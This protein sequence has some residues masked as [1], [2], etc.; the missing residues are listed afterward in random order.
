M[1]RETLRTIWIGTALASGIAVVITLIAT[2]GMIPKWSICALVVLG[3]VFFY[4]AAVGIGWLPY[5]VLRNT[6]EML[7]LGFIL[8]GMVSLGIAVRPSPP[9]PIFRPAIVV[10]PKWVRFNAGLVGETYS[11]SV[12]NMTESDMYSVVLKI[13]IESASAQDKFSITP[14]KESMR[15]IYKNGCGSLDEPVMLGMTDNNTHFHSSWVLFF[16]LEGH[17]RRDITVEPMNELSHAVNVSALVLGD[18]IKEQPLIQ[19]QDGFKYRFLD[20]WISVTCQPKT[21]H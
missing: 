11:F 9:K 2:A 16:K 8:V 13:E 19:D 17:E 3:I 7:L 15:P 21:K 18:E 10:S 12:R 4:G 14:T 20:K 6:K 1:D 5:F